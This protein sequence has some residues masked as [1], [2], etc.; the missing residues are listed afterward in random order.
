MA[1]TP[2]PQDFFDENGMIS[3]QAESKYCPLQLLN[4]F[5]DLRDER[6]PDCVNKH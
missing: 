3:D 5:R 1:E 6:P 2:F 4:S